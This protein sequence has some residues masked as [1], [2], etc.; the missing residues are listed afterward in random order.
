MFTHDLRSASADD[1]ALAVCALAHYACDGD[2]GRIQGDSIFEEV[3]ECRQTNTD[4]QRLT[5][6]HAVPYSACTDLFSWCAEHLG[7]ED[8]A[9]VNRNDDGGRKDW[10]TGG[11]PRF[12][13]SAP[14]YVQAPRALASGQ[15]PACGAWLVL[16]D[17]W[18][19]CLLESLDL[20]LGSC[21]VYEYGQFNTKTGKAYG[22]RNTHPVKR[23][24]NQLV[25]KGRVVGGWLPS[26]SLPLTKPGLMPDD[27]AGTLQQ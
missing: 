18:H 5:D 14:G 15:L 21:V 19:V 16:L 2:T 26:E 12:I 4:K 9:I 23:M 3:T 7:C 1:I 25:V 6:P 24:G 20:E 10:V 8:E 22:R 17:P 13:Q 27:F 11:G